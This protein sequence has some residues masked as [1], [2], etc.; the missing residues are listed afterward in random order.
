MH[1]SGL[2]APELAAPAV[3]G[4]DYA[5]DF[6]SAAEE[7]ALCAGIA[8]L[9]L[10]EA[11][12]K[13]YTARRRT[14]SF[15]A[16]LP[17]FLLPARRKIAAWQAMPEASFRHAL[18][19]EYRPGTP[20]GWHRDMP[21][22]AA[23]CGLSLQGEARMRFRRYPPRQGAQVLHLDLAPRSAYCLRG[24]ARW[25]WQHSISPTGGLR[26]SITFRTLREAA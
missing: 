5:P 1:A 8:A 11:P 19:S 23:V 3:E 17:G 6:L 16:E 15:G 12:Y 26:Y 21:E 9:A 2:F 18:V 22:F 13:E 20:L 25:G 7:A 4:L 10:E 24:E 14:A